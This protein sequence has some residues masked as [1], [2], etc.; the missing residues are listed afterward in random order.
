MNLVLSPDCH[1]LELLGPQCCCRV[2]AVTLVSL[3][4]T[5]ARRQCWAY[6]I[7]FLLGQTEMATDTAWPVLP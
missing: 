2:A 6:C 5:L 1:A 3:L 4:Q 7:V